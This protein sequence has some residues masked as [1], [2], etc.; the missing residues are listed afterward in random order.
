MGGFRPHARHLHERGK[1]HQASRCAIYFELDARS[2]DNEELAKP[3]KTVEAGLNVL[4]LM[5][6]GHDCIACAEARVSRCTE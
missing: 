2:M 3:P 4:L 6:D 1:P 5:I